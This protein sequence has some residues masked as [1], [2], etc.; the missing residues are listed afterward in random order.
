MVLPK[1]DYFVCFSKGYNKM[2][3]KNCPV[4]RWPVPA[5]IEHSK[6]RLVWFSVVN[7]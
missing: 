5:K 2:A 3:A 6:T 4:R 1:L 7:C